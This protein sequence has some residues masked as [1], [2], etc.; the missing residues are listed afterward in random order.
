MA[1]AEASGSH[2]TNVDGRAYINVLAA[3]ACQRWG[4]NHPALVAAVRDQLTRL[5]HGRDF[6][7]PGAGGAVQIANDEVPQG[8]GTAATAVLDVEPGYHLL[9]PAFKEQK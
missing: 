9:Q 8:R 2:I 1:I 7:A 3:P 5:T 4:H 6:P